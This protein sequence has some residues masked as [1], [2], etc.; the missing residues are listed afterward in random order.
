[1]DASFSATPIARLICWEAIS[2]VGESAAETALL[3]RAG[4]SNVSLSRFIDGSGSRIKLCSAPALPEEL[5]GSQRAIALATHALSSLVSKVTSAVP[6]FGERKKYMALALPERFAVEGK[7]LNPEGVSFVEQFVALLPLEL[8][9]CEI[10]YFP[11]G[12]AA[13]ALALQKAIDRTDRGYIAICGG[14]DTQYDWDVL[15]A[16][17]SADRLLTADNVDGLR[18]GEGA[19]F[20]LIDDG[21]SKCHAEVNVEIFAIGLGREPHPIG[22]EIPSQ[23]IGLSAALD[24]ALRPLR[25]AGQRSNFW[26]L[27]CTHENYATQELQNIVTRCGDV[28][29]LETELMMPSK[30]L[31]DVGA[32][33]IPMLLTLGAE[34]WRRGYASDAIA[35]ATA[36]SDQGGRGAVLFGCT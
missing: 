8:K 2:T 15:E 20:V 17:A 36:C 1:V 22:S 26:L 6:G 24:A 32:S 27:D 18:P 28:L 11:F 12:R 9:N 31:G 21:R 35:I 10:E 4:I 34:A 25:S 29:G 19:A 16:L 23:A 14:V 5:L 7:G 13:G 3:L 30:E 33:A